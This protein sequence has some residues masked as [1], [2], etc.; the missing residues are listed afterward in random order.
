MTS[1]KI[2]ISLGSN[3]SG[4]W[5]EPHQCLQRAFVELNFVLQ[6]S[7]T[8]SA[9]YTSDPV[10]QMRQKTYLNAVFHCRTTL[11]AREILSRTKSLERRAG[12]RS[13][14]G[15]R[16]GPRPLDLDLIDVGGAVR[17]WYAP[18]T[19]AR[20]GPRPD[21]LILPHP[22]VHLRPFVLVPLL[23]I[24]PRWMHPA[25]GVSGFRLLHRLQAHHRI[26]RLIL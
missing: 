3:A 19:S 16:W 18:M 14:S 15:T 20:P 9:L 7:G 2:I 13:N 8:W 21:R 10:G 4:L 25:F 26:N 23:E 5:G 6:C 17:N 11:P 22:Y 24:Q 1:K 12:R